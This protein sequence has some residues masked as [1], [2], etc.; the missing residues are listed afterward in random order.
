MRI[1]ESIISRSPIDRG[2]SG[3]RKYCAMTC[4]GRRYLLR[5]SS[6]DRLERKRREYGKMVEAAALGIPMCL[7]IE[8]GICEA[9]APMSIR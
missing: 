7:P 3:D 4:D 6:I 5:I 9:G 1:Y 2:W 8:F